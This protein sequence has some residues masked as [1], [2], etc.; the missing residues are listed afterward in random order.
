MFLGRADEIR[1]FEEA[2]VSLNKGIY[3]TEKWSS[4]VL[5]HG[6]GGIG[7][8]AL[9]QHFRGMVGKPCAVAWLD[10]EEV[11]ASKPQLFG[12]DSGPGLRTVLDSIMS[13][14][15]DGLE[16][17]G[18]R[19]H[20]EDAFDR[21]RADIVRLPTL[22]DAAR[23]AVAASE[24]AGLTKE[25]VDAAGKA[26]VA[27]GSLLT[28][29]PLT[30]PMGVEAAASLGTAAL[31]HPS[32]LRRFLGKPYVDAHDYELLTDPFDALARTFGNAVADC[33]QLRPL[34]IFLDTSEIVLLQMPWLRR[35]MEESKGRV[36]WVIGL[37]LEAEALS[38]PHSEMAKFV[39]HVPDHRLRLMGLSRFDENTVRS[40]LQHKLP[41]HSFT[42]SE[43]ARVYDFTNGLPLAV[44][45]VADLLLHGALLDDACAVIVRHSDSLEPTTPGQVVQ[46]LARRFLVHL[47]KQSSTYSSLAQARQDLHRIRCLAIVN[48]NPGHKPEVLKALWDT[49]DNLFNALNDLSARHDFVLSGNFRLH[50]DVRAA[51][52]NDLMDPLRRIEVKT[53]CQRAANTIY[54]KLT[55]QSTEP[56]DLADQLASKKYQALLLDYIWYTFWAD[57]TAGWKAALTVLP[58]LS[59]TRTSTEEALLE[60]VQWFA[61]REG[62]DDLDRFNQIT[63]E[64]PLSFLDEWLA[65]RKDPDRRSGPFLLRQSS[66][67]LELLTRI[68]PTTGL[69]GTDDDRSGS[70]MLLRAR[71]LLSTEIDE[72]RLSEVADDLIRFGKT[73][74]RGLSEPF[75][76]T[77]MA[78]SK[79]AASQPE[80]PVR[81]AVAARTGMAADN[82]SSQGS[83]NLARIARF[84]M[85]LQPDSAEDLYRRALTADPN[86]GW[87]LS[88]YANFLTDIRHQH[89][90]AEKYYQRALTADPN[91]ANNLGNYAVFLKNVRHQHDQ[92][93]EYYQRAITADPNHAINLCNYA[94]FLTNVRQDYDQA[95]EYYQRALTA[96]PNDANNLGNYAHLLFIQ[97]RDD[98]AIE[99]TS[100]AIDLASADEEPLRAECHF[101]LFMH[102]PKRHESSGSELKAF[103]TRGVSTGTW[104]FSQHLQRRAD[105]H[106]PRLPLLEAIAEALRK[107]D[108]ASL[109]EFEEWQDLAR[110]PL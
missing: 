86:E 13:A 70:L 21:Y 38:A 9:I 94:V 87:I 25:D 110:S 51:L 5:V 37:R 102:V 62:Q 10:F 57:P 8:S 6:L 17:C 66:K 39:R 47:E 11:R 64:K 71:H 93:E 106:D 53:S 79:V 32:W 49:E 98:E 24:Q 56:S 69:L 85:H 48:G 104:D 12:G 7:K 34:V 59:V 55:P 63:E 1:R 16:S 82:L 77:L 89:D 95:E 45:L 107:G 36:I 81:V 14:C 72:R 105:E 15:L 42:N 43:V 20:A 29:Q 40:Y 91:H 65:R 22:L 84:V 103:L 46:A 27:L 28:G 2:L 97:A 83:W 23:G 30:L 54:Q 96:D 52:R 92:A 4:V 68:S 33:S 90:Q 44:S 67:V 109:D 35:M 73:A 58:V 18:D 31:S 74:S 78:T 108:P 41:S 75:A 19:R 99:H 60:F 61:E 101:Y 26:V 100:A 50:D 76:N 88:N 80:N 3:S